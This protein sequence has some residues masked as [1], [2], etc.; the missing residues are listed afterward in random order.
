MQASLPAMLLYGG[1][2]NVYI[3]KVSEAETAP[4]FHLTEVASSESV[5]GNFAA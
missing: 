2:K 5:Q 4:P 3:E 1:R